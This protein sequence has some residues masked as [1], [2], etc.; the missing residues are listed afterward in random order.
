M[1]FM[2]KAVP[3]VAATALAIAACDGGGDA[4]PTPVPVTSVSTDANPR[5]DQVEAQLLAIEA[6]LGDVDP[7]DLESRMTQAETEIQRLTTAIE[8]F[9]SPVDLGGA[10][11][12]PDSTDPG[13]DSPG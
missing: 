6:R 3:L 4:S 10:T 2:S 9:Q 5:L 12:P 7:A 8:A 1:R 11:A 13:Q